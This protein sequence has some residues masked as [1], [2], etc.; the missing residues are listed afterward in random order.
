MQTDKTV[1]VISVV[2]AYAT[3]VVITPLSG[4]M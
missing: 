4:E 2:K 1:V 3:V